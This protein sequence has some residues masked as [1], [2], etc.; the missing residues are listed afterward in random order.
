MGVRTAQ[1]RSPLPEAS[2]ALSPLV[3]CEVLMC[4]QRHR[5]RRVALLLGAALP[6]LALA[7]TFTGAVVGRVVDSQQAVIVSA[8]VTLRS[9]EQGFERHTTTSPQGTYSFELVPPG[10]FT[11]RAE[12]SGFAPSTVSVEVVV[13]T[14]VRAD[15]ILG[16]QA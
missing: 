7:Q 1:V 14:P 11:I 10:K 15:L 9:M 5:L 13:A 2:Q 4:S 6:S 8:A 3:Q 12:A 16:V